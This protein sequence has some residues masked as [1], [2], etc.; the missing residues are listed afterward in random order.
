MPRISHPCPAVD[1]VLPMA[2]RLRSAH[3]LEVAENNLLAWASHFTKLPEATPGLLA[4]SRAMLA[5]RSAP[6]RAGSAGGVH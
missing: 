5:L 3:G 2:L 4:C 6:A 1:N